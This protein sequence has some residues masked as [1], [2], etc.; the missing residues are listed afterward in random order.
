MRA[1]TGAFDK[2]SFH[3]M[4][5]TGSFDVLPPKITLFSSSLSSGSSAGELYACEAKQTLWYH[6]NKE[7]S[8]IWLRIHASNE[9]CTDKFSHTTNL[10][11]FS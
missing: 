4:D 6:S 7:K 11:Q 10:M 8:D 3:G 1:Q 9:N 2:I 5:E